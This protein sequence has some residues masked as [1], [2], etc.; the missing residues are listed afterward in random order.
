MCVFLTLLKIQEYVRIKEVRKWSLDDDNDRIM[1]FY[2]A[3]TPM[4]VCIALFLFKTL[5]MKSEFQVTKCILAFFLVLLASATETYFDNDLKNNV[6]LCILVIPISGILICQA[7]LDFQFY[8][9]SKNRKFHCL[10]NPLKKVWILGNF[11]A[12]IIYSCCL[13]RWLWLIQNEPQ[14]LNKALRLAIG[15]FVFY[16]LFLIERIGTWVLRITHD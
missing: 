6:S 14:S 11:G 8:M 13:Y 16:A 7:A 4:F 3:F 15:T 5:M 2:Q 10:N 9:E 1:D 12:T